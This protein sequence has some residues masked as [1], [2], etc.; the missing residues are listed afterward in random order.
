MASRM[1]DTT[2]KDLADLE[3]LALSQAARATS[4]AAL[5]PEFAE[6]QTSADI[7]ASIVDLIFI[8][9]EANVRKKCQQSLIA[10]RS[11][12]LSAWQ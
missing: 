1:S 9:V 8:L 12:F 11:P 7:L 6:D 10:T 5:R 3:P 2:A 4:M